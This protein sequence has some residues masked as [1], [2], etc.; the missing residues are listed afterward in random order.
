M[1]GRQR[2]E[3]GQVDPQHLERIVTSTHLDPSTSRTKPLVRLAI[4]GA[5]TG[6]AASLAMAMYAMVAAWDKDIGFFTPLYHIAS[7]FIS[8]DAMMASM[9]GAITGSAFHFEFGPAALGAMVHMMTGAMYGADV[10]RSSHGSPAPNANR[11]PRPALWS[12]VVAMS[13]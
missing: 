3:G 5:G 6:A 9:N 1:G 12:V 8:Q 11:R 10:S 13:A 4:L 2:R 7:L